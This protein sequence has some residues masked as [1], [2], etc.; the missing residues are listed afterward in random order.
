VSGHRLRIDVDDFAVLIE[1]L[2]RPEEVVFLYATYD[3]GVFEIDRVEPMMRADVASRSKL[4]V[5]LA[6]EVRPR[7]IKAAWDTDHCLIEA[8]SHGDW[9][10]AEF[11][12][13]DLYGFQDWVKHVRWR[14]GGRPY[15]AL[16][17]AGEAWD[18]LA[19]V[20]GDNP[21]TIDVI[22]ITTNG[23]TVQA[24]APTSA[25]AARLAAEGQRDD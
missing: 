24:V 20:D 21:T 16:V 14:L 7:V 2:G 10:G 19:W 18:A 11:S 4:H 12:A 25:T 23:K 13:S 5:E 3:D 6:D 8:H 17:R 1:A 9:G 15:V 22:E